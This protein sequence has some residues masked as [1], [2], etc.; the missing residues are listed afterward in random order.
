MRAAGCVT[1]FRAAGH[2][3]S[4]TGAAFALAAGVS[5]LLTIQVLLPNI[6]TP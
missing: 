2:M 6:A 5:E 4:C 1:G 3:T